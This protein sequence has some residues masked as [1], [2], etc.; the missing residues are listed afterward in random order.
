MNKSL[1]IVI[2]TYHRSKI[3][4]ENIILMF[5]ECLKHSIP[6]YISDDSKDS[7]TEEWIHEF[8]SIYPYI[9]YFK[10]SPRLGHDKNIYQALQMSNAE[11]IWLLG[12]STILNATALRTVLDL[13]NTKNPELIS[14]NVTNRDLDF[15]TG[16]YSDSIEIIWKFGWHLNLT[17]ATIYPRKSIELISEGDADKYKNFPQ[18]SLI[19]NYLAEKSS[20]YW[21]N[22]KLIS[23][24]KPH[25]SYWVKN[26][27]SVFIDD[28]SLATSNISDKIPQIALKSVINNHLIKTNLLNIKALFKL[29]MLSGY[30]LAT[31]IKYRKFIYLNKRFYNIFPIIAALTP[32][33]FIIFYNSIFKKD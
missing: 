25:T 9:N 22:E 13:I 20:F 17:G 14:V 8:K 7:K 27:F 1:A 6:I 19:F 12:D 15:P 31:Y 4:R 24:K 5:E 10:N 11:Y 30:N 21:I 32:K 26:I 3:L 33:Y 28:W 18:F 2:P 16:H 29:R 23:Y